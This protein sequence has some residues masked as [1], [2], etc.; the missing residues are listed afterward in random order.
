M[1]ERLAVIGVGLIA[2]LLARALRGAAMVREI[3]GYGRSLPNLERARELGVIDGFSPD[4][5]KAVEGADLVFVSVPLGPCEGSSRPSGTACPGGNPD[6][7][8]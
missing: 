5:G 3:I 1:I 8:G 2:A 6:R 4:L 7:W